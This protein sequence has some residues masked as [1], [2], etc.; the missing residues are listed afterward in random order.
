M[1]KQY[2]PFST[3]LLDIPTVVYPAKD[4]GEIS[5]AYRRDNS[6]SI[7]DYLREVLPLYSKRLE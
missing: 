5:R 7:E 2:L 3:K 1:A 4:D 6:E